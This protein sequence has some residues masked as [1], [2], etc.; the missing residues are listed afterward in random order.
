MPIPSLSI[1]LLTGII[2]SLSVAF[3]ASSPVAAAAVEIGTTVKVVNQVQAKTLNRKLKL[4]DNVVYQET[5]STGK[6]SAVDIRLI[7][8]STLIMGENSEMILDR[9]VYNP[10]RGVVEGSIEVLN[11][12]FRFSGAAVKMDVTIKTPTATIGV[13][14]TE[15]DVLTKPDETEIAVHEGTIEVISALGTESVTRGQVYK[16][17]SN[18]E[19]GLQAGPSP[20]FKAQTSLM[21]TLVADDGGAGS[22]QQAAKTKTAALA[23]A[24]PKAITNQDNEN[25][26]FM[27]LAGGRAVIELRPDLAPNHVRRIKEMARQGIYDDLEFSFVRAGYAAETAIPTGRGTGASTR[28]TLKAEFSD[29]PFERGVVGMSHKPDDPDS[30]ESQF[31]ITLNRAESLDGKYTVIGKVIEGVEVLDTLK[32]G[33]P[34]KNPDRIISLKVGRSKVGSKAKK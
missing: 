12:I 33:R 24:P 21:L 2:L 6:Q 31:F 8:E 11:G 1:R 30:A 25:L 18:G 27:E 16:V 32:T 5:V 13:R 26:I 34:P 3:L 22:P 7:D 29:V 9:M 19:G 14:G 10:N 23:T 28:Q 17:N 20:Q 4:G 15:F